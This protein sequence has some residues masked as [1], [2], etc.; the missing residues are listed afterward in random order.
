MST[1]D[2]SA[3]KTD[4]SPL[5]ESPAEETRRT[6]RDDNTGP[7]PAG[8]AAMEAALAESGQTASDLTGGRDAADEDPDA[9]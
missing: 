2:E 1:P 9:R 3:P 5:L 7:R 8:R 6:A 4:T